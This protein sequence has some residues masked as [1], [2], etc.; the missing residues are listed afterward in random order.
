MKRFLLRIWKLL[1]NIY[2]LRRLVVWLV[3]QKFLVGVV[4]IVLRE[5]NEVLLLKHSYRNEYPW[6][7]PSGWLKKGE[8]P[9]S[10]LKREIYEETGFEVEIIRQ[11]EQFADP[12]YARLDLIYLCRLTDGEFKPSD[13]I[14]SAD[15]Y[16][17]DNLPKLISH[18]VSLINSSVE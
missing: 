10:A 13:E 12:K 15:F 4:G 11:I 8:Q 6:G 16:S 9:I 2:S 17:K 14:L 3:S 5:D 1:P 7:L 18:Q